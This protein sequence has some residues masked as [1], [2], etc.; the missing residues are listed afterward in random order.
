MKEYI[1]SQQ[2]RYKGYTVTQYSDEVSS[3][4]LR[5]AVIVS[6]E[7]ESSPAYP[8]G[9]WCSLGELEEYVDKYLREKGEQHA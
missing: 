2:I 9:H 3:L 4:L 7:N 1:Q 5:H 8:A 6:N